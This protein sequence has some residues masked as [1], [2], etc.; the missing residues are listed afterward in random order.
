MRKGRKEEAKI[1]LRITRGRE[2]KK[3]RKGKI[4]KANV[5][6]KRKSRGGSFRESLREG[7]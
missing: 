6:K 3:R 4:E 5:K 2:D 7:R 1:V